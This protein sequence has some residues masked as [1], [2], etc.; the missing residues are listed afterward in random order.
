VHMLC[1]SEHHTALDCACKGGVSAVG[2]RETE[3]GS[4]FIE[5]STKSVGVF[6]KVIN[7]A[8]QEPR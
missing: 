2:V 6:V 3:R 7:T 5:M 1:H 8:T 4:E